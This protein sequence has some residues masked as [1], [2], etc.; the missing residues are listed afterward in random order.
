MSGRKLRRE[1]GRKA[2]RQ[3]LDLMVM[4]QML[5][6]EGVFRYYLSMGGLRVPPNLTLI[7]TLSRIGISNLLLTLGSYLDP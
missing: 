5:Q 3:A 6:I 1:E 7:P 2:S 4:S